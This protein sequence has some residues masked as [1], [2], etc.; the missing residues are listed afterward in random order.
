MP[1]LSLG[2]PIAADRARLVRVY[3]LGAG[4]L[5]GVTG[6]LL[7]A[8]PRLAL[9]AMGVEA[10]PG[11]L[12]LLRWI[13]AFVAAV[14]LCTLYPLAL[15]GEA[16]DRRLAVAL[17]LTAII[18]LAV[19]AFTTGALALGALERSWVSVPVTDL[20]LAATQLWMIRSGWIRP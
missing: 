8:A 12:V 11:D 5:D 16:R 18:R 15:A 20:A 19:F 1:E 6:V 14:G 2:A 4:L 9:A 10:V 17:E 3:C 13:G 7:V